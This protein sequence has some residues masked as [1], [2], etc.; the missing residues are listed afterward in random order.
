[1]ERIDDGDDGMLLYTIMAG[2]NAHRS[3]RDG[4]KVKMG[5]ERK[6][7]D[8]GTLGPAR[9]GYVNAR[10]IGPDGRE[11]RTIA[12]DQDRYQMIQFA[13]DAFATGEHSI[14][15]LRALLEE[16]GFRTRPTPKRPEH[17]LS[18]NGLYR[19]L[20]DDYFTG[21]VT[22][23]G[24]KREGRHPAIIDRE[25]FEKVQQVLDAHRLSGDRAKKHQHYLKGSI[26]CAHC[27]LRLLYGRHRGK[28]GV[29]EYFSCLSHQGGRQSCGAHYMP[30]EAVEKG[31]EGYYR[32]I[33]LHPA[34][35]ESVRRRIKAEA[36]AKLGIVHKQSERHSRRL[37]TLQDEQQKLL[38]LYY[39]GGVSEEVL[40]AEQQRIEAE[41]SQARRLIEGASL[42][43]E[44]IIEALDDALVIVSGC[45]K[46]YLAG[47]ATLR[48]MMNQAIFSRFLVRLDELDGE[49][50]TVFE[51]ITRL[52]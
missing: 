7:A 21:V 9:T 26:F 41:R 30:V 23:K 27:G 34:Q 36:E 4:K 6:F 39:R 48:R 8:G 3:R 10:E 38:H 31:I 32:R 18:R 43:A 12:L 37:R 1:M 15:T 24:V 16:L 29:Y 14:T 47:D 13:F 42:E 52:G 44:D 20:R 51:Y 49:R 40:Q 35:A 50:E 25:T 28:G 45:H 5:M 22:C 17:P 11:V 33:E 19:I 46:T 2:I